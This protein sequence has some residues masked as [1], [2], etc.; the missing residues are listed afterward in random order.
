MTKRIEQFRMKRDAP[1]KRQDEL[2]L[3][4]QMRHKPVE[5]HKLSNW[6]QEKRTLYN[7]EICN[8]HRTKRVLKPLLQVSM[9]AKHC[10]FREE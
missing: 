1:P 8:R 7:G 4:E 9:F 2:Q 6:W 10:I 5:Q 3:V